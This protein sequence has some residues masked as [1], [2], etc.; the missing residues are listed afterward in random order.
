MIG[1]I[2][3]LLDGDSNPVV[4]MI[5][6]TGSSDISETN[7]IVIIA[8]PNELNPTNLPTN[9]DPNFTSSTLMSA[10]IDVLSAIKQVTDCNCA[11]WVE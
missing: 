1:D 5:V 4:N 10:N 2:T 9:L 7:D 3:P 11:C 6:P 8:P